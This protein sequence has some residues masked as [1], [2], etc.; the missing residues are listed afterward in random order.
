MMRIAVLT[1]HGF[2]QAKKELHPRAIYKLRYGGSVVPDDVTLRILAFFLLYMSVFFVVSLCLAAMGLDF[3]TALGASIA[4]L[5][6]IGP[7]LGGVGPVSTFAG[8]PELGKL[9]LS[10][11]MLLG[12]LELYTVLVLLTP[13]FWKRI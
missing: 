6:N 10:A 7:G 4:S 2:I 8:V 9:L 1:K 12:R 3:E 13:A 5:S 11:N